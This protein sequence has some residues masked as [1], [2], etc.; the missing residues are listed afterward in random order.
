MRSLRGLWDR[1]NAPEGVYVIPG[2][3]REFRPGPD[4]P[5]ASTETRGHVDTLSR[6]RLLLPFDVRRMREAE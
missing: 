4:N 6:R 5:P 1:E 2:C 3:S